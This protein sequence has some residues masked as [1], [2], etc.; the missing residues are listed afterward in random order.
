MCFLY[1]LYI[2]SFHCIASLPLFCSLTPLY[3]LTVFP[4]FFC[5]YFPFVMVFFILYQI[6]F[7][8]LFS[9]STTVIMLSPHTHYYLSYVAYAYFSS[10]SDFI[11]VIFSKEINTCPCPYT[12]SCF[13][14]FTLKERLNLAKIMREQKVLQTAKP[15]GDSAQTPVIVPV[16]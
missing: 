1:F 9:P 16:I 13:S 2:S 10:V 11:S 15:V 6:L 7:P 14:L 4:L 5:T 8:F 12:H 3:P